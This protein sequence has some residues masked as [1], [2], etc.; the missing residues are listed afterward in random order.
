MKK[1][2]AK[3]PILL[4]MLCLILVAGP[5]VP[6]LAVSGQPAS[7]QPASTTTFQ[8]EGDAT[9]KEE[10]VYVKLDN[11]GATQAAYVVNG[12]WLAAPGTIV[13]YGQYAAVTNLTSTEP[14]VFAD[15]RLQLAAPAGSFYYQ[16]N[17]ADIVLPWSIHVDYQLNGTTVEPAA[18]AGASGQLAIRIRVGTN[19]AGN[20]AF[21]DNYAVQIALTLDTG[22]CS[23][24]RAEQG[25]VASSGSD[26]VVTFVKLPGTAADYTTTLQV[27]DFAMPGITFGAL[28]LKLDFTTPDTSGLTD[29]FAD[30]E[31]GIADLNGGVQ[32]LNDGAADLAKGAS[33]LASGLADMKTG[34]G[35]LSSGLSTLTAGNN[36][37]LGGSAAIRAALDQLA[38]GMAAIDPGA[39]DLAAL[40]SGS[41]AI[42][43]GLDNLSGGLTAL[44]GSFAQ[45]DAAIASSTGNLYTSLAQANTATIA[46]LGAQLAALQTDP[47]ANAAAIQQLSQTIALLSANNQLIG[48]LKL[49]LAGDGSATNPGLAAGAAQ[50][51]A[52]YAAFDAAIQALPGQ[53]AGLATGLLQLQAAVTTLDTE[54]VGFHHG[55]ADYLAGSAAIRD[56]LAAASRGFA[57]LA[58]G[59]ADLRKGAA[60]L[61][62]GASQ[63]AKG[64]GQLKEKTQGMADQVQVSIDEYLAKLTAKDLTVTSFVSPKNTQ[65]QSVQ[66]V[67]R[68]EGIQ[69]KSQ[70]EK[71]TVE[72]TPTV[73][74]RFLALFGL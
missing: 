70:E 24:I 73:W 38:Q 62:D 45:A 40:A 67:L 21:A 8:A 55:L 50:L 56:G 7:G 13:D 74:D 39:L 49:G 35:Q 28:P 41:S 44:T 36:S 2:M 72:V 17:L 3:T 71:P 60:A 9:A 33:S 30:L 16:G 61:A 58:T 65:I 31:L 64:S 1:M 43:T 47:V 14:L 37:L 4:L 11:H 46:A 57:S 23:G 15:G 53:I 68:T 12:F 27:Q 34:L 66:F 32:G 63:V 22:R 51:A 48:G 18:L 6:A 59:G 19:P 20:A 10:V 29:Q 54:Y 52:Q 25:T 26:K 42:L 69:I 5:A